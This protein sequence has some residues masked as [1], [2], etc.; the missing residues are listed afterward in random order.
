ML[1]LHD[2]ILRP[3]PLANAEFTTVRLRLIKSPRGS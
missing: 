1:K 3:Q 2:A